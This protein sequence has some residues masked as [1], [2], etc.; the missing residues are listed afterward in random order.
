MSRT[1]AG[2]IR[3][4]IDSAT[5]RPQHNYRFFQCISTLAVLYPSGNSSV[6]HQR[7]AEMLFGSTRVRGCRAGGCR[8]RASTGVFF[9]W[10][11]VY[12]GRERA[13]MLVWL[14]PL[15]PGALLLDACASCQ[16]A[17][18]ISHSSS[19]TSAHW[20]PSS[21]FPWRLDRWATLEELGAIRHLRL[22]DALSHGE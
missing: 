17:V 2:P 12:D 19:V 15:L 10:L 20:C 16:V 7:S 9:F 3:I 21:A 1:K 11:R 5:M 22:D 8:W 18:F 6:P 13:D 4:D 14:Q